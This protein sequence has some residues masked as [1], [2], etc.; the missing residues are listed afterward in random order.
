MLTIAGGADSIIDGPAPV[1]TIPSHFSE[2]KPASQRDVE[3]VF[4][5][6]MRRNFTSAR[7]LD[8]ETR[9]A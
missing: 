9:F 2:V 6:E 8:M 4:G 5:K 1:K 3:L 7:R